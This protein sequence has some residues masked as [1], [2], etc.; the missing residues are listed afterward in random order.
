MEATETR[1]PG[2]KHNKKAY[3]SNFPD[4]DYKGGTFLADPPPLFCRLSAVQTLIRTTN[5]INN[6]HFGGAQECHIL[7]RGSK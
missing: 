7:L 3:G 1:N 2:Q 5:H 6:L 4:F